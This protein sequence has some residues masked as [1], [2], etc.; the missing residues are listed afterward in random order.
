MAR[1]LA[2]QIQDSAARDSAHMQI[3]LQQAE[4]N[5]V[6]ARDWLKNISDD[7]MRSQAVSQVAAQWYR[8]D[9][10]AATQWVSN[11]PRGSDRD[12]AILQ[13]AGWGEPT[14]QRTAL[15]ATIE[16]K[17]KRS[18]AKVRQIYALMQTDPAQAM[19]MLEDGDFSDEQR[20]DMR[21]N[22]T[23]IRSRY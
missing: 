13:L 2:D 3:L 6:E 10:A 15:I 4:S 14:A 11:M 19:T 22:I 12:D 16:D 20:A 8:Q 23:R 7:A 9:P 21:I 5:P 1:Q 18:Q 17:D